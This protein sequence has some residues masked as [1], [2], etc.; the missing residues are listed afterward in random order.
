VLVMAGDGARPGGG[1]GFEEG[2]GE[3]PGGRELK[4]DERETGIPSGSGLG[5]CPCS[6]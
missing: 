4:D 1:I 3:A 2:G 6:G 5:R